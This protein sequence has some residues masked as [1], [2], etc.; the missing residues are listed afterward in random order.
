[1]GDVAQQVAAMLRTA[2]EQPIP[3]QRLGPAGWNPIRITEPTLDSPW[4]PLAVP[5][6]IFDKWD[7]LGAEQTFDGG[8]VQMYLGFALQLVGLPGGR[9]SAVYFERGMIVL[10]PDG[11]T[12]VVYGAIYLHYREL[13]DMLPTG[14]SPGLPVSDEEAVTNGRRSR[15]DGA[16][17]YWSPATGAH[18]VHGAIRDHWL[19][20]GGVGGF[21][22]FPLTDESPVLSGGTEIGRMNL[23]QGGSIYWSPA[24]GAWEVHGALRQAW[25]ERYGGPTGTLGWPVSDETGS[26][27]GHYRYNDFQNGCLTWNASNGAIQMFKT[28]D[29]YVDRVSSKGSHTFFE[30]IGAADVWVYVNCHLWTN[31]GQDV[32]PRLPATDHYGPNATPAATLLTISPVRGELVIDVNFDG[33]DACESTSDQHLGDAT[34]SFGIDN[35]WAINQP[36]EGWFGDF[37]IAY[38]V[39][40]RTPFDPQ[41][42]NFREDLWWGFENFDTAELSRE[43]YGQ[44]FVD[45][46]TDDPGFH[47]FDEAFYQAVYKG[48]AAGGNCFGMCLEGNDALARRALYSE[49]IHGVPRDAAAMNEV[50]IRHGYQAGA[51]IVDYVVAKF[52]EG[53]THDPVRAFN[54]SRDLYYR[55]DYP[56]ISVTNASLGGSGHAVRPYRWDQSNPN[57][58]V[59]YIAN[60]NEASPRVGDEDEHNK[61]HVYPG[62]NTFQFHFSDGDIWSGGTWSGGRMFAMPFSI[63]CEEPRTP[64]WEVLALLVAGTFLILGGDGTTRQITDGSGRTFYDANLTGPPTLWEHLAPDGSRIPGMA[65]VPLLHRQLNGPMVGREINLGRAL[66]DD[67]RILQAEKVP[68]IYALRGTPPP[69]G[70]P[71][72]HLRSPIL[73][74]ET[75]KSFAAMST[76]EIVSHPEFEQP[77]PNSISISRPVDQ[78]AHDVVGGSGSYTWAVRSAGSAAVA[79]V[80]SSNDPTYVDRISLDKAGATD[81]AISVTL[82]G[83]SAARQVQLT[84]ASTTLGGPDRLRVFALSA[85]QLTPG[86]EFTAQLSPDGDQILLNNPGPPVT[87]QLDARS[88]AGG[89]AVAS[90]PSVT[91]DQG[92]AAAIKPDDWTPENMGA[93]PI[94]VQIMDG[95]GGP[96]IQELTL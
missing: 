39:Q 16:D 68:E 18:E 80:P 79:T 43:Q 74:G 73:S 8:T 2:I 85:L 93:T 4:G 33:W 92:K 95:P 63:M 90:R 35:L 71:P 48:M 64:F 29:V 54:E 55:N 3:S 34:G 12:F 94:S 17:L 30:S 53:A 23:F 65:R 82:A 72:S 45:V 10:R 13:G 50:N 7:S 20:L 76:A 69:F 77:I 14:W 70:V 36:Q 57:D 51:S 60:P 26:P 44:T 89:G 75:V 31:T 27:A 61:I 58:W 62:S 46:Q 52:V 88:G 9:G 83:Q 24:T 40:N 6:P 49:S 42:P 37:F 78:L 81:Q 66:G 25:I 22:G 38:S 11:Q 56:V 15:F 86:Q 67:I 91:I 84:L 41:D 5:Q 87:F 19:S 1:M 59:I 21:L 96:V 47:P 28:L 32:R